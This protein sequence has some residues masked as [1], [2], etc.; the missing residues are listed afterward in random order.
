[1]IYVL[2]NDTLHFTFMNGDKKK[3]I[4]TF[5]TKWTIVVGSRGRRQCKRL[6][7]HFPLFDHCGRRRRQLYQCINSVANTPQ[8]DKKTSRHSYSTAGRI[9]FLGPLNAT[10]KGKTFRVYL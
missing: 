9:C 6:Y 3:K 1:M 5:T 8:L 4:I 10:C 7:Y 2:F